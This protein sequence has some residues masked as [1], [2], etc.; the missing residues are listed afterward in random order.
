MATKKNTSR[1]PSCYSVLKDT[2]CIQCMVKRRFF[3]LERT[4][5]YM[6]PPQAHVAFLINRYP[7]LTI[8]VLIRLET[9]RS[10]PGP[11]CWFQLKCGLGYLWFEQQQMD[12]FARFPMLLSVTEWYAGLPNSKCKFSCWLTLWKV[13]GPTRLCL[14][15][16]WVAVAEH[17]C[18]HY[19]WF[20]Q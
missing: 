1:D 8:D 17:R 16:Q 6:F 3:L 15:V 4:K 20:E 10:M 9:T 18:L 7:G 13:K 5:K 14:S 12:G 2:L 11:W 19:P